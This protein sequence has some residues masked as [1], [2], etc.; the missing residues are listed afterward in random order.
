VSLSTKTIDRLFAR[1]AATYGAAWDRS[2]GNAP[3]SDVKSV[4]AHELSGFA[5]RLNDLGWALENLPETAPNVMQFRSL[6]RRAP[7]PDAP[8]LPEPKADPERVRA[9]IAKLAPMRRAASAPSYDH[10]AWARRHIA[11]HEAGERIRPITLRFAREALG[12]REAA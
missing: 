6:C 8:R 7:T 9:E 11:R 3:L 10:K 12:I 5:D 1:M 2:L 4:W